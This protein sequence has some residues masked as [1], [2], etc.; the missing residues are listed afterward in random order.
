MTSNSAWNAE[1]NSA[2]GAL[3]VGNATRPIVRTV[4]ADGTA[5]VADSS[6][7]DGVNWKY[8]LN[9]KFDAFLSVGAS[10]VTGAGT[11]WTFGTTGGATVSI[12]Y[13]TSSSLSTIGADTVFT[14]PITGEYLF[15]IVLRFN[16]VTAAM[17]VLSTGIFVNAGPVVFYGDVINIGAVRA[18]GDVYVSCYSVKQ[19]FAAGTQ[20]RVVATVANGAGNT[21]DIGGGTLG[22]TFES[23]F[24][25]CLL[26]QT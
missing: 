25:G 12:A 7:P 1:Y 6:Q 19:L 16:N 14:C 2:K 21:L 26:S 4:G 23:H 20:I 15:N 17:T 18:A 8:P 13:D 5:L 10:N 9:P 11:T 22:S 24:S 3:L